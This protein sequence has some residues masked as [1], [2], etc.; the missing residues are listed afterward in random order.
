MPTPP[1]PTIARSGSKSRRLDQPSSQAGLRH[2]I[3]DVGSV[4][5][6]SSPKASPKPLFPPPPSI[7]ILSLSVFI[8]P[9][10]PHSTFNFTPKNSTSSWVEY[11]SITLPSCLPASDYLVRIEQLTIHNPGST[12]QFYISRAQ[13]KLTGGG[14]GSGSGSPT[15]AIPGHI[16]AT[17]PGYTANICNNSSSYIVLGPKVWIC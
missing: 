16:K 12:P 15:V 4:G 14:S 6:F 8:T 2:E 11:Y 1:R 10:T 7:S 13:V 5:T 9:S 3:C 17:D